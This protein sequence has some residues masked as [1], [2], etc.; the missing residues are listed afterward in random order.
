[1]LI[2][3]GLDAAKKGCRDNADCNLVVD[4]GCDELN[5]TLCAGGLT[6]GTNSSCTYKKADGMEVI[7]NT[8][9]I[10]FCTKI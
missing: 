5:I 10:Y 2:F 6:N 9:L 8:N 1:M 3:Q 7:A 4:N